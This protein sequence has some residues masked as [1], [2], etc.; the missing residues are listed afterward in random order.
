MG[1]NCKSLPEY[2]ETSGNTFLKMSFAASR[3][4]TACNI[5]NLPSIEVLEADKCHIF[6]TL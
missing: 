6:R 1:G 2:L 3:L 5:V 4:Y